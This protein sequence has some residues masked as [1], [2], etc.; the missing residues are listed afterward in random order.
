MHLNFFFLN[1]RL[2]NITNIICFNHIKVYHYGATF[3][4]IQYWR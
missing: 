4:I 3:Q 1:M 2:G